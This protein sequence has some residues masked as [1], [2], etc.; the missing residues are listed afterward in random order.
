MSTHIG[1]RNLWG[2]TLKYLYS[3]RKKIQYL[4]SIFEDSTSALF[5]RH[6][7][8]DARNLFSNF[9]LASHDK[10]EIPLF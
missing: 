3:Q 4:F 10:K 7:F 5:E 2:R 6:C 9:T 1:L 8:I